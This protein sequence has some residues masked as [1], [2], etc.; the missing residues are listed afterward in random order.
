MNRDCLDCH[1]VGRLVVEG[2]KARVTP[3]P[4]LLNCQQCHVCADDGVDLF[5]GNILVGIREPS[6]LGQPQSAGPPLIPQR[7]FMRENCIVCHN[8]STR[9]E[10][11]RPR[12]P[13]ARTAESVM[14]NKMRRWVCLKAI[15]TCRMRSGSSKNVFIT[16]FLGNFCAS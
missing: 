12:I 13:S 4:E 14:W 1:A 8:A 7:V 6:S 3:H 9:Q 11:G 10:I 5:K 15:P 2:R 16:F